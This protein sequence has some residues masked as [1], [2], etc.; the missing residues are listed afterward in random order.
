MDFQEM[1]WIDLVSTGTGDGFLWMR[2]WTFG[3]HR[4]H[5]M[6]LLS[7]GVLCSI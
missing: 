1:C 3:L 4:I 7:E 2:Q 6:Y 5:G